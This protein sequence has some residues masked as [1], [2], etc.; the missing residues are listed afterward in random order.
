MV[1]EGI[2]LGHKVSSHGLEVVRDKVVA[3]E[4]LPPP[5][6]IKGIWS[7]L[8]HAG[9]FRRFIKDFSKITKPLCNLL[10][11]YSTFILDADYL[12]AFEK[13]NTTLIKTPI[14]IWELFWDNE[15]TKCFE[16]FTM[17]VALWMLHS[18]TTPPRK[19]RCLQLELEEAKEKEVIKDVFPDEQIFERCADQVI[20]RFLVGQEAQKILEHCH[21]TP[22]GGHFGATQTATK[23]EISNQKVK[24]ILEKTVKT[25]WKDWATKLDDALGHIALHSRIPLGCLHIDWC[26]EKFVTC[27]WS[28][29]IR[30]F[31]PVKKL[32]FDLDVSRELRK[33]QLNELDEFLNEAYENVMIYK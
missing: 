4:K 10:E 15:E 14:M 25:N 11:K 17:L 30:S 2:V 18:K 27:R 21:S 24:Q 33:L 23:A 9:F 1:Q 29:N 22:Y 26:M 16:P 12:Q 20:R 32:N 7:F 6:N 5:K 3:I 31:G 19:R 13:I 28:L 8:G